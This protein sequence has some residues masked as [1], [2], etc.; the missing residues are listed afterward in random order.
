ME[1]ILFGLVAGCV[2]SVVNSVVEQKKSK[3]RKE[4]ARK[5]AAGRWCI[6]KDVK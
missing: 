2:K 1:W 3:E 5:H 6:P 4:L